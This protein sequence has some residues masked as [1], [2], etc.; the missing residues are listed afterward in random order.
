VLVDYRRSCN[1]R[2]KTEVLDALLLARYGEERHPP[3]WHPLPE[4]IEHLRSLLASRDDFV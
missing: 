1:I 3:A 2:S 4:E